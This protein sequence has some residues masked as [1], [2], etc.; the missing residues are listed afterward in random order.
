[1]PALSSIETPPC[2]Y[3]ALPYINEFISS[4]RRL[5]FDKEMLP[6]KRDMDICDLSKPKRKRSN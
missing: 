2:L 6:F 4:G 3:S 1:M 5:T